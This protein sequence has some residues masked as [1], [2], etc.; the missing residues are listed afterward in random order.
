ML[1]LHTDHA[2]HGHGR[3]DGHGAHVTLQV[4]LGDT[5]KA[6]ALAP[7]HVV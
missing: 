7:S 3:A 1:P 5:G 4:E 6:C 2:D